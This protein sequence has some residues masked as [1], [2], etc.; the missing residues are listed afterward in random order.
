MM[1][2]DNT[3]ILLSADEIMGWKNGPLNDTGYK[4]VR[5][6]DEEMSDLLEHVQIYDGKV[7][8]EVVA[9]TIRRRAKALG[10]LFHTD[11]VGV[12]QDDDLIYIER[13]DEKNLVETTKM[14]ELPYI[15]LEWKGKKFRL[16]QDDRIY[17]PN[18]PLSFVFF[19][20]DGINLLGDKAEIDAISVELA[21]ARDVYGFSPIVVSQQNRAMGD[22]QRA[23]LHGADLSPQLE[24]IF[25]SS[26]MGFDADLVIGLFD[27]VRYKSWDKEGKYGGYVIN[28]MDPGAHTPSTLTPSGLSRFRSMHI[29]KNTFGPDGMVFGMKFL[30]E[31]NHFQTLPLPGTLELDQVYSDIRKGI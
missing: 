31:C 16:N 14:G 13:F 4:L 29:L 27:P 3:D 26:Q 12:F 1:Y 5:S 24:D 9:R 6:Y 18:N 20:I 17:F 19:I 30:G 22:I 21:N 23:K 10:T 25:K 11:D 8:A 2:R 28:P 7:S 15:E